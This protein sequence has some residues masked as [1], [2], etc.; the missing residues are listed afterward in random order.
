MNRNKDKRAIGAFSSTEHDLS[1]LWITMSN[2]ESTL[3][4]SGLPSTERPTSGRRVNIL[5]ER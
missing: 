4:Y 1:R 5:K 3:L 2:K